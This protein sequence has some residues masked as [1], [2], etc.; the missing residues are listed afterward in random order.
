[1]TI[2]VALVSVVIC[3]QGFGQTSDN[4]DR[5]NPYSPSPA[6]RI[7]Q[8]SA[9]DMSRY[10]KTAAGDVMFIMRGQT[11]EPLD[12]MI[13]PIRKPVGNLAETETDALQ[14]TEIYKI[15]V[16]DILFINLKNSQHGS[17]YFT[18]HGDGTIDYPLA[19]D[20]VMVADRTV[21]NIKKTLASG[22][23]LFSDPEVDVKVR[24]YASH[25][26]TVSGLVENP[27]KRS[28]QREAMPIFVIRAEAG[29]QSKATRALIT[30]APLLPIESYDLNDPKTDNVL[31]YP[32]NA[33]EFVSDGA[34]ERTAREGFFFIVGE[35]ASS[36]QKEIMPGLTLYQAVSGAGGPKGSAKKVTLRRKNEKGLFVVFE[37]NLRSIKD[38]K[39]PDPAILAGDVIE[40]RN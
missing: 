33:I 19:G 6:S 5:N 39:S 20:H 10:S 25:R 12:K 23:T 3:P 13:T 1:M 35:I 32:G 4:A 36:G 27:G 14:P 21:E 7:R 8:Q 24:E 26:I 16:G 17:G 31:V 30:R 2:A 38:G 22:I 37:H 11:T 34:N 40:I 28:L 29:A 9:P 15:G 18:V